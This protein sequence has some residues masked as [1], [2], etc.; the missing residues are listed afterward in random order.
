MKKGVEML[1]HTLCVG[2][3]SLQPIMRTG[4]FKLKILASL[5]LKVFHIIF[6]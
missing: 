5:T 4:I 6:C 1:I 2:K 3:H